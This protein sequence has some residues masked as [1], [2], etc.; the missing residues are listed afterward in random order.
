VACL[1]IGTRA[2]PL[3]S[4]DRDGTDPSGSVASCVVFSL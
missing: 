2:M 4:P 3:K 1:I